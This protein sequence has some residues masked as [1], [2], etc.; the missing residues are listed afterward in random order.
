MNKYIQPI[1]EIIK[2]YTPAIMDGSDGKDNNSG[3]F[4]NP[5][6]SGPSAPAR[7]LYL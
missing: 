2:V 7:K 5:E 6:L 3:A 4:D 1:T